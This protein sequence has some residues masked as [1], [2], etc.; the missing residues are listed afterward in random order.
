MGIEHRRQ[1]GK[2]QATAVRTSHNTRLRSLSKCQHVLILTAD[3]VTDPQE[4]A[5]V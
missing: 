3:A 5:R 4:L 1:Q 2:A